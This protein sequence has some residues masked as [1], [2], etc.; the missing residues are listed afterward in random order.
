MLRFIPTG[1]NATPAAFIPFAKYRLEP[2]DEQSLPVEVSSL[3][4]YP[5]LHRSGS[6]KTALLETPR[7]FVPG[8]AAT[9]NGLSEQSAE[10]RRGL[11]RFSRTVRQK[12]R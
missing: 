9:V 2:I 6:E 5:A 4:P 3:I 11:G 1:A 10:V 7:M 8:Y 12:P